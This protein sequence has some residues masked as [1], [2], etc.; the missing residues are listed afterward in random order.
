MKK[1]IFVNLLYP[2]MRSSR[3]FLCQAV[4]C[5]V[6]AVQAQAQMQD[7]VRYSEEYVH[8]VGDNAALF[9]GRMQTRLPGNIESLYL[10]E[11]GHIER[12]SPTGEVMPRP[13]SPFLSYGVGDL[14]YDGVLYTGVRMRLDLCRDELVAA[15]SGDS[16]SG[17]VLD[18]TRF[19]YAD[20][21]GYRIIHVPARSP[22]GLPEGYYLQLHEGSHDI[23]KKELFVLSPGENMQFSRGYLRYYVEKD[24]AYHR[25]GR[26]NG[27]VL[28]LFG[29]RRSELRAFIRSSGVEMWNDT[30]RALVEIV[31]E[32][33]RLNDR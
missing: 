29:D 22:L 3:F 11:R 20:L 12:N 14:F 2:S 24:G 25:V 15:P 17:V 30:E 13:V 21:R 19:G 9:S 18:P 33:E 23:L 8:A 27:P 7:I 26:R 1:T 5:F 31:R 6:I 28:R 32:Y 4:V 16:P 10:R